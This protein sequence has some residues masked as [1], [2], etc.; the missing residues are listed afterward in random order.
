[1]SDVTAPHQ[2]AGEGT[3][4]LPVVEDHFAGFNGDVIAFSTLNKTPSTCR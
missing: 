2:L 4:V 1:M 3:A